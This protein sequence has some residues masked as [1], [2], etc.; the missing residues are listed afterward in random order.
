MLG[1]TKQYEND[2]IEELEDEFYEKFEV[3]SE[4]FHKIVEYLL[5]YSH[6]AKSPLSEK[7]L[8]GFADHV[9]GVYI[10]KEELKQ[11]NESTKWKYR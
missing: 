1:K 4:V 11:E 8:I 2:E 5:P 10:I 9:N 6:I 3:D 7:M